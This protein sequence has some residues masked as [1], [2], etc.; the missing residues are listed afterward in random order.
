MR[1]LV[2][3]RLEIMLQLAADLPAGSYSTKTFDLGVSLLPKPMRALVLGEEAAVVSPTNPA[4]A[5]AL[6]REVLD[7]QPN[8][9][10]A[11]GGLALLL[12]TSSDASVRNG[13]E[14]VK[15]ME[16]AV[17]N[18]HMQD[19]N[20][21]ELMSCAYAEAG[22]WEDAIFYGNMALQFLKNDN[23]TADQTKWN[24]KFQLILAHHPYHN[25]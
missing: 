4:R 18:A 11:M 3:E 17:K 19:V 22:R 13:A 23:D 1:H 21:L 16:A 20:S 12:S 9:T 8:L 14:A 6:Y 25:S 10:T 5:V 24:E 15:I 2:P 7:L